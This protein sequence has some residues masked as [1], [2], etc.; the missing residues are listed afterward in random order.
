MHS[1]PQAFKNQPVFHGENKMLSDQIKEFAELLVREVRDPAIRG[2]DMNRSPTAMSVTAKRWRKA[3]IDV[4]GRAADAIIPD[5]V[6]A[7]LFFLLDAIDQGVI[8]LQFVSESGCIVDLTQEGLSELAGWYIGI[9]GF[10]KMYSQER[11]VDF[12]SIDDGD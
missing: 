12:G 4:C 10:R 9:D 8:K 6:D 3:G 5:C 11:S 7:T 1:R 2:C